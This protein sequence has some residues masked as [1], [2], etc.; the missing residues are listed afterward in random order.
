MVSVSGLLPKALISAQL[1]K[2]FKHKLVEL[3]D[4]NSGRVRY[5]LVNSL[6]EG[7]R[8]VAGELRLRA[9]AVSLGL[10]S[11]LQK[12]RESRGLNEEE[13]IKKTKSWRKEYDELIKQK[14]LVKKINPSL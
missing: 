11:A 4:C 1:L 3:F 13:R 10:R 5:D 8:D 6:K 2:N 14:K 7:V 9:D 12:A